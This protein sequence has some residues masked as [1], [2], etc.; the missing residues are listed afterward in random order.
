MKRVLVIGDGIADVYRECSFAKMCPDAPDVRAL[1]NHGDER[2]PGGASNVALNIAALS[3]GTQV[4]LIAEIPVGLRYD[5]KRLSDN[6]VGTEYSPL[7]DG[8]V[9]ERIFD[10]GKFLVRVD[11][12]RRVSSYTAEMVKRMLRQYLAEHD[13]DLVVFSDYAG[14]SVNIDSL[15]ILLGMRQRLLV[16]TKET[17][18]SQFDGT[19]V[20]KLNHDEWKRVAI[21]HAVPEKFCENMIV[22]LGPRGAE[23]TIRTEDGSTS[24]THTLSVSAHD[25]SVV[26]VCGSGDTFIAGLAA[27]FLTN[28]DPYTAM[29]FANAAAAT[30]VSQ[31]R[32]AIANLKDT[33]DLVKGLYETR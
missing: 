21:K 31:P 25:V 32:V 9:K 27:S 23:L 17:D 7:G 16:D 13:P 19:F 10:D 6:R 22:T 11:N 20:I 12:Q 18:L 28:G 2:R 15:S 5:I 33:L 30:V 14:G 26:D 3:P 29:Q 1:L 24:V 8:L 4:D